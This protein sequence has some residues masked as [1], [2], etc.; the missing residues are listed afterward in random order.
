MTYED[1][2]AVGLKKPDVVVERHPW[3]VRGN[4]NQVKRPGVCFD[5]VLVAMR[6]NK[7]RSAHRL[8]VSLFRRRMGDGGD[9]S[10]HC[11]GKQETLSV[12]PC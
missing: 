11:F 6:R 8:R 2:G 1:E 10:T 5:G 3:I 9:F 7:R 12:F 4:N